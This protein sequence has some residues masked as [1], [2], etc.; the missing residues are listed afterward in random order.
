MVAGPNEQELRLVK[1]TGMVEPWATDVTKFTTAAVSLE[2][3]AASLKDIAADVGW[4]GASAISASETFTALGSTLYVHVDNMTLLSTVASAADAAVSTARAGLEV[5]EDTVVVRNAMLIDGDPTITADATAALRESRA[6]TALSTL[7]TTMAT[8]TVDAQ[9]ILETIETHP[10]EPAPARGH[11]AVSAPDL[12]RAPVPSADS[13]GARAGT[14]GPGAPAGSVGAGDTGTSGGSGG[15]ATPSGSG[16]TGG[17]GEASGLGGPDG[18]GGSPGERTSVAGTAGS[19]ASGTTAGWT[20]VDGEV[21][22]T[23]A[24]GTS[25]SGG[26]G[27]GGPATGST[28]GA[29]GLGGAGAGSRGR[30]LLVAGSGPGSPGVM[31]GAAAQGGA[32]GVGGLG[33]TI[34]NGRL[35]VPGGARAR[36]VSRVRA[37]QDQVSQRQPR[38]RAGARVRV[39]PA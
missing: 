31:S 23:A 6:R 28:A 26:Y 30:D 20:S 16:W 34:S 38:A 29:D 12:T 4:T 36:P 8:A 18:N 35:G 22:G 24:S 5:V 13:A 27:P 1:D 39:R 33:A 9:T 19:A 37:V 10:V 21:G 2:T 11:S 7:D 3:I 14:V 32:F 25:G 15:F 17:S